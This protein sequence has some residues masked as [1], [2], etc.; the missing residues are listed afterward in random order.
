MTHR[1]HAGR[2]CGTSKAVP[3]W[4]CTRYPG[5]D[6]PCAARRLGYVPAFAVKRP[7]TLDTNL[8][9]CGIHGFYL[10]W[11][12]TRK[13]D[14]DEPPDIDPAIRWCGRGV[15]TRP[16]PKRLRARWARTWLATWLD[17][18]FGPLPW[19]REHPED[20]PTWLYFP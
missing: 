16:W 13:L 2:S 18:R 9:R 19:T 1:I 14:E 17:F 5:H 7:D 12:L 20:L 11:K 15:D 10:W 4:W 6:G 8:T 3:G